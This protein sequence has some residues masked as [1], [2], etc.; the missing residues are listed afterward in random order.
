MDY[1]HGRRIVHRDIKP[2]NVLVSD[3]LSLGS[4]SKY[5]SDPMK[6]KIKRKIVHNLSLVSHD[7]EV[8]QG[9]F[10]ENL[11]FLGSTSAESKGPNHLQL[12]GGFEDFLFSPLFGEDSH[13][14]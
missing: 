2:E 1:L 4:C 13:F 9:F 7:L 12:G 14:D 5:K 3:D 10:L 11:R 8:L 6:P